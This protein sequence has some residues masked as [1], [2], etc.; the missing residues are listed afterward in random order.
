MYEILFTLVAFIILVII[1]V[2][3]V[4]I[5]LDYK[6]YIKLRNNMIS[7][8]STSRHIAIIDA[9]VVIL[10]YKSIKSIITQYKNMIYIDDNNFIRVIDE[11]KPLKESFIIIPKNYMG[12]IR[13]KW[14]ICKNKYVLSISNIRNGQDLNNMLNKINNEEL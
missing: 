4:N 9:D 6:S 13:Y 3:I 12:W 5:Y 8:K 1:Y 2:T 11:N 14:F 10:Q 7:P